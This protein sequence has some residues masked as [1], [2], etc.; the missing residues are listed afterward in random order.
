MIAHNM[1][2]ESR[3]LLKKLTDHIIDRA[4]PIKEDEFLGTLF[5]LILTNCQNLGAR[6]KHSIYY[7]G[8]G[9]SLET[10]STTLSTTQEAAA[11]ALSWH[12]GCLGPI[13]PDVAL[14]INEG[15]GEGA[16][17]ESLARYMG[18]TLR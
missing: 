7:N 15:E 17:V 13:A 5:D 14:G 11:A 2:A 6:V 16:A 10:L 18:A 3:K 9:L 12:M 8:A 4:A 1:D